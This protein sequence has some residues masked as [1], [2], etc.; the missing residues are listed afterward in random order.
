MLLD[1]M[2]THIV[3]RT[4]IFLVLIWRDF[5]FAGTM[6]FAYIVIWLRN[7]DRDTAIACWVLVGVV[8]LAC[9]IGLVRTV[10]EVVVKRFNEQL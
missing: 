3:H 1:Q 2:H 5:F 4:A 7:N 9:I 8:G 10:V 6:I